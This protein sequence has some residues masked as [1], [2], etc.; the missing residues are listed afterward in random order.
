[1]FFMKNRL[2][3]LSFLTLLGIALLSSLAN[4]LIISSVDASDIAPGQESRVSIIVKNNLNQDID[5][6]SL[7]LDFTNLPLSA[8]TSSEDTVDTINEDD[9]ETFG[10]GIRA[11]TSAKEGDYKVPYALTYRNASS[12]QR[13]T[14]SL[15]VA[16]KPEV[17]FSVFAQNA[18]VGQKGKITFKIVN[19][20]LGS[21]K[22]IL[23]K[24]SE[25]GFK[26]LS[27]SEVYIGTIDSNDFDTASFDVIYN[28]KDPI[29]SA[30]VEYRDANNLKN[31]I[32]VNLP[33]TVYTQEEAIKQGIIQ[34]NNNFL[35]I[36]IVVFIVLIWLIWRSIKKR[37][38]LKKSR[39]SMLNNNKV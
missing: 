35:Y 25:E 10:F 32:N 33:L 8:T 24:A 14:I 11:D 30:I 5:D 7:S 2:I 1:M 6:V 12:I 26:I 36:L 29:F 17:T 9:K 3:Y 13:G 31:T 27:D 23:V 18:I 22:F 15:R 19:K 37:R 4:A 34:K 21:A 16:A 20:G 39:E 28:T 38:R